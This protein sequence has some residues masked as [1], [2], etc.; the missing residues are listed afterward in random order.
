M[1]RP[2]YLTGLGV[3]LPGV[4]FM[5]G[6]DGPRAGREASGH[7]PTLLLPALGGIPELE[8]AFGLPPRLG[9]R[10]GG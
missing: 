4:Y 10:G 9:T 2:L 8:T 7:H 5:G 3:G 6:S 1:G